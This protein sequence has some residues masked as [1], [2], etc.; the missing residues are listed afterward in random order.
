[1]T[2]GNR[3]S[4]VA[5]LLTLALAAS[6]GVWAA[7]APATPA[8]GWNNFTLDLGYMYQSVSGNERRF[9][10]YVVQP[11]GTY[12]G[13]IGWQV[14]APN[15]TLPYL[16]M[17]LRD[18]GEPGPSGNM[19]LLWGHNMV[20]QGQFRRSA[21]YPD[22][23]PDV[24][25]A[26]K[27][28]YEL[29]FSSP[30][31]PTSRTY[32][33]ST[34]DNWALDADDVWR[35]SRWDNTLGYRTG[36]WDVSLNYRHDAFDF[37][38]QD[39]FSGASSTVGL[40]I[41][42]AGMG[43]TSL[44]GAFS[45]DTVDLDGLGRGFRATNA[46]LTMTHEL[47]D[48][49]SLWAQFRR[50]D[51]TQ[52]ITQNAYAQTTSSAHVEARYTLNP[53]ASLTGY[54]ETAQ[55]DYVDGTQNSTIDVPKNSFGLDLQ[56]RPRQDLSFRA[57]YQHVT[58]TNRPL[59]QTIEGPLGNSLIWGTKAK[60]QFSSSYAPLGKPWGLSGEWVREAWTNDA[61][62]IDN[63]VKMKTLTAWWQPPNSKVSFTGTWMRQSF[64]L[65]LVDAV[66]GY[67]YTTEAEDW[68]LGAVYQASPRTS[69]S[70]TYVRTRGIGAYQNGYAYATF[71]LNHQA[72]RHDRLS[73][74]V[75]L[76]NFNYVFDN[77]LAYDANLYNLDWQREF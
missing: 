8:P 47:K 68:V 72:G 52:T 23:G 13:L 25:Q 20:F 49:L 4:L 33:R 62:N 7:D 61:Q 57:R 45:I 64:D 17:S 15:S 1:M 65:P 30:A 3:N 53:R 12:P 11:S 37:R 63:Q 58:N 44:A 42:S 24:P 48:N 40:S 56:S 14:N 66:T 10:Q 73:A 35:Q 21:F 6:A 22:F 60:L 67:P 32:W 34:Y 2:C 51:I 29:A 18:L 71:G 76:S 5:A 26:A 75:T 69:F 74:Q 77:S 70:A 9:D 31:S 36:G 38:T 27:R 39:I 59:Y 46:Q 16:D 55:V 41:A 54:L 43:S 19:Y 28:D 50:R